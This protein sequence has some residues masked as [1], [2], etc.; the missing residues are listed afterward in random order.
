MA[1]FML[2]HPDRGPDRGSFIGGRSVH[3]QRIGKLSTWHT[4]FALL[5]GN[6]PPG[7][8]LVETLFWYIPHCSSHV[9]LMLTSPH[10][11]EKDRRVCIKARSTTGSLPLK[12]R[13]PNTQL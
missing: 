1:W 4:L 12:A 5:R 9:V 13:P 6:S 7:H 3:N 2:T 8:P 11:L 10:L